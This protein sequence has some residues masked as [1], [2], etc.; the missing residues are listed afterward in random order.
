LP[1]EN[2]PER[3][4]MDLIDALLKDQTDKKYESVN[5]ALREKAEKLLIEV[6]K[7]KHDSR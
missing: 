6:G 3:K 2:P 7:K 4:A 1:A 5:Q